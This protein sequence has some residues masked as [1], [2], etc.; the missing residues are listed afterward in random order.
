M[1]NLPFCITDSKGWPVPL[2]ALS[3]PELSGALEDCVHE[4]GKSLGGQPRLQPHPSPDPLP[5]IEAES[6]P[7]P[8]SSDPR[9]YS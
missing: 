9:A 2:Q 1:A 3:L 7:Y 6:W 8:I 5:R 4:M